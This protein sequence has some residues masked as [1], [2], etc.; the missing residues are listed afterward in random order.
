MLKK[1]V[2]IGM[3]NFRVGEDEHAETI[4]A[5]AAPQEERTSQAVEP[6]GDVDG[7]TL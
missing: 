5:T 3:K 2:K 6:E 7:I 1:R 4:Q